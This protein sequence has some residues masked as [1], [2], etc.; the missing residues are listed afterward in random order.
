MKASKVYFGIDDFSLQ[1]IYF[2]ISHAQIYIG[3]LI[4]SNI[5]FLQYSFPGVSTES[6]RSRDQAILPKLPSTQAA[7]TASNLK[8]RVCYLPHKYSFFQKFKSTAQFATTTAP[9][10]NIV[11]DS[12]SQTGSSRDYVG[13]V[14]MI[15]PKF[16][17]LQAAVK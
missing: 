11:C 13:H 15:N 1:C 10:I 17:H 8:I 4:C 9:I 7:H 16:N 14:F 6:C 3:A 12:M 5:L 2:N